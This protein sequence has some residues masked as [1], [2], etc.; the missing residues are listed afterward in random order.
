MAQ[1]NLSNY[2]NGHMTKSKAQEFKQAVIDQCGISNATYYR[3]L[4]NPEAI[5]KPS[6]DIIANLLGVLPSKLFNEPLK[7]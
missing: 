6:R 1:N 4:E 3:W 2:V 5:N 7:V